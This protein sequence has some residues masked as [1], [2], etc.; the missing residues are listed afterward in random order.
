MDRFPDLKT[1]REIDKTKSTKVRSNDHC[2]IV[3][4]TPVLRPLRRWRMGHNQHTPERSTTNDTNTNPTTPPWLYTTAKHTTPHH[5]NTT[6]TQQT[7][8]DNTAH[9]PHS[10][11]PPHHREESTSQRR[12]SNNTI[13]STNTNT[14][15]DTNTNTNTT[16][17]AKQHFIRPSVR[18][19]VRS[20]VCCRVTRLTSNT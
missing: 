8:N 17:A 15:A 19:F 18:P 14:N 4:Q 20:E 7:N 12:V 9:S 1:A 3:H 16:A 5:T 13:T 6:T 11:R 10:H 2:A